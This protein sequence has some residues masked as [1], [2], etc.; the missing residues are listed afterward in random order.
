MSENNCLFCRIIAGEIP[1]GK[2]YEDDQ[3]FAFR[4]I[5]PQA[6][7]HILLIPKKHIASLNDA[8][9]EDRA[10]LGHLMLVAPQIAGQEG[11]SEN[12]YRVVANTGADAG[13]TV[14]HIHLHLLGGR[15]MTWPPG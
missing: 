12:G 3:A 10:L 8:T 15:P 4:D 5:H 7:T 6:P 14:W 13:Q 1:S 2:V 11:L 9:A